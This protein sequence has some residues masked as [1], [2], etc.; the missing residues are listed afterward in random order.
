M[1]AENYEEAAS[2][3]QRYQ[4][5]WH[6]LH[7]RYLLIDSSVLDDSSAKQLHI[8]QEKLK[9]IIKQKL[10]EAIRGDSEELILRYNVSIVLVI[11]KILLVTCAF[12]N[13]RRRTDP[14]LPLLTESVC[15][16]YSGRSFLTIQTLR[17]YTSSYWSHWVIVI[18]QHKRETKQS[19]V[20]MQ[21]PH[22][23]KT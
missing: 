6:F 23:L 16:W 2:H 21:S 14:I 22:Y 19:L 12:R 4:I 10:D 13:G 15:L 18:K 11:L 5:Y 20:L 7:S 3:I 17:V 8:S 1:D 9:G